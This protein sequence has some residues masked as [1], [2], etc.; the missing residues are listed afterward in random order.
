VRTCT[1]SQAC[2]NKTGQNTATKQSISLHVIKT[3]IHKDTKIKHH[4]TAHHDTSP[5]GQSRAHKHLGKY[6]HALVKPR[7]CPQQRSDTCKTLAKCTTFSKPQTKIVFNQSTATAIGCRASSVQHACENLKRR[8]P[9]PNSK[10][11]EGETI[12]NS[13]LDSTPGQ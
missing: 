11:S 5:G 2:V 4:Q 8:A 7:D 10:K 13:G 12:A 1:F 6:D 9:D 3:Q